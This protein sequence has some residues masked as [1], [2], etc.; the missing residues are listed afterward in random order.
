[1][2]N[3]KGE[4]EMYNSKN[5][6]FVITIIVI[7]LIFGF[8]LGRS[9]SVKGKSST[10]KVAT[11]TEEQKID[12]IDIRKEA[13]EKVSPEVVKGLDLTGVTVGSLIV[14][15]QSAGNSVTISKA[16]LKES[17]W[18]VIKNGV[19]I[20]GARW[21]Q[22]GTTENFK[23]ELLR[24][25]VKATEYKAEIYSDSGDKKFDSKEDFSKEIFSSFKT[26]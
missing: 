4:E 6:S 20:L 12:G 26:R 15:D 2:E 7:G 10:Q 18:I 24:P 13:P 19:S 3:K 5:R 17:G 9:W 11:T 16:T 23:V 1:M 22:K 21:V 14:P 25:T 8:Y